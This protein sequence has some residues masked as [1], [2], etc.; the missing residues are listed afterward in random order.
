MVWKVGQAPRLWLL[1]LALVACGDDGA[2]AAAGQETGPCV[3]GQCLAGLSCLS[4]FCVDPGGGSTTKVDSTTDAPTTESPTTGPCTPGTTGCQCVIGG[5][6]TGNQCVDGLC[7]AAIYTTKQ[8]SGSGDHTCAVFESG[9]LRCWGS[10][11]YSLLGLQSKEY[12]YGDDEPARDAPLVDV[13]GP[14]VQVAAGPRHTCALLEGGAV[15]CWGDNLYGQLGYG[16]TDQIGDDE[17]PASAGDVSLGGPAISVHV[18]EFFSCAV[19][20]DKTARCWGNHQFTGLGPLATNIGDDD[21]PSDFPPITMGGPVAEL[22]VGHAQACARLVNGGM[23]CWGQDTYG[24]LGYGQVYQPDVDDSTPAELGD[25]ALG[26]TAVQMGVG[27]I[28][29]CA[30]VLGGKLRCWG[31]NRHGQLGY[32]MSQ[33][34]YPTPEQRGDLPVADQV[35]AV[36][37]GLDNTCSVHAGGELR[38]WGEGLFGKNAN[39]DMYDYGDDEPVSELMAIP[40]G[41]AV[42]S[43]AVGQAQVCALLTNKAVRCWGLGKLLGYGKDSDIGDNEY[44]E[45]AGDVPLE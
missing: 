11:A 10:N 5:C 44:P 39:L 31:W 38:C 23:R 43:V 42:T 33:G 26:A 15:R 9:G 1:A 41:G 3:D 12:I 40:L 14:V 34:E 25:I 17:S 21:V 35:T 13:G 29:S 22:A 7:E 4:N 18:G 37:V 28:H 45:V 8:I 27:A 24:S 6:D 16:H 2:G 36:F 20:A 30:V 19:M 32:G